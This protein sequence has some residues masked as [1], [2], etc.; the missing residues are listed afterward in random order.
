MATTSSQQISLLAQTIGADVKQIYANIGDLSAL[1]GTPTAPTAATGTKTTQLATT[2]F[3][4]T[5][6]TALYKEIITTNGGT[7]PA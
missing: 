6:L 3:V 2:A 1:T 7:V 5:A 4:Y